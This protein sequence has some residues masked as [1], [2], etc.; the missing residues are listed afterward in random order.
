MANPYYGGSDIRLIMDGAC[1]WPACG[2]KSLVFDRPKYF[3]QFLFRSHMRHNISLP[4]A[5]HLWKCDSTHL[6]KNPKLSGL[7]Q[8][9]QVL[10]HGLLRQCLCAC[11]TV[12]A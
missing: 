5:L 12:P 2:L 7:L 9:R 1:S 11:V 3:Q 4:V 10:A 6:A 8:W